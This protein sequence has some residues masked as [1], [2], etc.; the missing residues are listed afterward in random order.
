MRDHVVDVVIQGGA[1]KDRAAQLGLLRDRQR[2]ATPGPIVS[3][4]VH[5]HVHAFVRVGSWIS[6]L[7][8]FLSLLQA[9]GNRWRSGGFTPRL[10]TRSW[11]E[12]KLVVYRSPRR[13]PRGP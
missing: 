12:S 8:A 7:I 1:F 2:S 3:A 10:R 4:E 11:Q 9:V 5:N 6:R 13:S